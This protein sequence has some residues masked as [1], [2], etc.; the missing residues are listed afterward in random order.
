MGWKQTAFGGSV[1]V[2]VLARRAVSFMSAPSPAAALGLRRA[3]LATLPRVAGAST[4]PRRGSLGAVSRGLSVTGGRARLS[5]AAVSVGD[6]ASVEYS[7]KTEDGSP[8]ETRFDQ[9]RVKIVVG[10]GG[11]APFLHDAVLEME[12]GQ[13]KEVT[14]PPKDAFGEYD[15]ELTATLG[16]D[17]AP[18]DVSVGTVLQLWTGQKA[19]VTEVTG[20]SFKIDWNPDL[21]GTSL[22]MDVEVLEAAKA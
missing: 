4:Q 13:K 2:M 18:G 20:E 17:S 15:P 8:F 14:V 6:L 21:A 16:M 3:M 7:L 12:P 10:G 1:A 19:T 11:F 22:V 9:G 5:M